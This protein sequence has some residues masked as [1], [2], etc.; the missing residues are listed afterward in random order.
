MKLKCI[1]SRSTDRLTEGKVYDYCGNEETL[2]K[3]QSYTIDSL[4]LI[5]EDDFGS[6]DRVFD[7]KRFVIA[8]G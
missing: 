3:A 8:K 1:N 5:D 7:S 2:K 4:I 6:K